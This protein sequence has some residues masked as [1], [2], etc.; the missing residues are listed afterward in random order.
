MS[1]W[2]RVWLQAFAP[3]TLVPFHQNTKAHFSALEFLSMLCPACLSRFTTEGTHSE[4]KKTNK[5]LSTSYHSYLSQ[6]MQCCAQLNVG[7]QAMHG[8][9]VEAWK[10][11]L[12]KSAQNSVSLFLLSELWDSFFTLLDVSEKSKLYMLL[13]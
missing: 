4:N 10:T 7:E 3:S 8:N 13:E 1:L 6:L 5:K 11:F 2:L 12:K 9:N